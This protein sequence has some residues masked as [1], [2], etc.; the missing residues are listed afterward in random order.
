MGDMK[1]KRRSPDRAKRLVKGERLEA[2]R[3][4]TFADPQDMIACLTTERVRLVRT[5]RGKRLTISALAE[6]LGRDRGAVTRDVKK[7]AEL[8]LVRVRRENNPGHGRVQVVE[9]MAD[10]LVMR[11]EI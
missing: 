7:L 6:E 4:I 11:A 1:T 10:K 8:G 5:V 2:E 3:I 9:A